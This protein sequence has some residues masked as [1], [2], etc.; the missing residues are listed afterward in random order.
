MDPYAVLGVDPGASP[1]EIDDAYARRRR[2]HDPANQATESDRTAAQRFQAE[3]A[4]AYRALLGTT[5]HSRGDGDET[6][7]DLRDGLDPNDRAVRVRPKKQGPTPGRDALVVLG[8]LVGAYLVFQVPVA[9]GFGFGGLIIG[10]IAAV[11][12]VAVVLAREHARHS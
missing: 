11:A 1:G 6:G 3:L 9:L 5:P 10:L 12:L 8:T 7:S 4:D 2:L